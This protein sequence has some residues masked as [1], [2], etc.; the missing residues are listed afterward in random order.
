MDKFKEVK[1]NRE[2]EFMHNLFFIKCNK[3]LST[4]AKKI[5]NEKNQHFF[6]SSRC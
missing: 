5:N 3:N 6:G 1:R 2:Q 4:F